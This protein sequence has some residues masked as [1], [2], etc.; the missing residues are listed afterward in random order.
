[1]VNNEEE[2]LE[3]P[4]PSFLKR[5]K[6]L[7][8][9]VLVIIGVFLFISLREKPVEEVLLTP[10]LMEFI[11]ISV[12]S[13]I[14]YNASYLCVALANN[15]VKYCED[16][17]YCYFNYY[18][19]TAL[20]HN[21]T[22]QCERMRTMES[23]KLCKTVLKK[24]LSKC[25]ELPYLEK[26]MCKVFITDNID[27][28]KLLSLNKI[29]PERRELYFSEIDL[30]EEYMDNYY[31]Y[32]AYIKNSSELCYNITEDPLKSACTL[33]LS[34]YCKDE[35]FI[36]CNDY[37]YKYLALNEKNA[38]FCDFII[39]SF[40]KEMCYSDIRKLGET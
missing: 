39:K 30:K 13:C 15:D 27:L 3:K 16:E 7:F 4:K 24:D 17:E 37:A 25:D 33:L 2:I 36:D 20:K 9:I 32:N 11:N 1:M 31:F 38:T 35:I 29:A 28:Y 12:R 6:Y 22:I 10:R 26:N 21:D 34:S 40:P 14:R 23:E 8:L 18:F 19:S 5:Y